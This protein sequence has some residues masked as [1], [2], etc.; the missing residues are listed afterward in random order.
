[1]AAS[2]SLL[3]HHGLHVAAAQAQVEQVGWEPTLPRAARVRV[4][5][6]T[7]ICQQPLFELCAAGGLWF[8]R[9]I[10]DEA[11]HVIVESA[12]MLAREAE[13]LWPRILSGQA[14]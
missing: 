2:T 3:D 13:G 1:M 6:H 8:V 4:R 14:R 12:W 10:S 7:C 11:P 5:Q 9:R